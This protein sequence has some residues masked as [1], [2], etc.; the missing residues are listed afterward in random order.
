MEAVGDTVGL[1]TI[2]YLNRILKD[3]Q[4]IKFNRTA[5]LDVVSYVVKDFIGKWPYRLPDGTFSRMKGWAGSGI[6]QNASY[7]WA[8][9]QYMGLTLLAR[10]AVYSRDMK[11]AQ[12]VAQM[13]LNFAR[14][15]QSNPSKCL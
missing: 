5:Y 10:Y 13:A 4:T 6:V 11:L 14:Y 3:S 1:F 15:V 7:V 12:Q 8:D 9:D 2:N